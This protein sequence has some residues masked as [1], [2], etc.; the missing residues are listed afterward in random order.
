[1]MGD[2]DFRSIIKNAVSS[3]G[4]ELELD[5]DASDHKTIHAQEASQ[6]IRRSY[7]DRTDPVE[8]ER[9]GFNEL[10]SGLLRKLDYGSKPAEYQTGDSKLRCQ[11]DMIVD[12]SVLLFRSAPGDMDNPLAT[13]L[14]YLNACLWIYDK[15]DGMIVY[16]T[17]DRKETTFSLARDRGMFEEVVRRSKVL[18]DLLDSKKTPIV[19]P[20]PECSSCQYYERCYVKRTNT[21]Q[22]SLAKMFGMEKS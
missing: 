12:D 10:L 17:N 11:A 20:S 7:Y 18:T 16:I 15:P 14:L 9:R 1:M 5:I 6:C 21:K 13:D 22:L 3:I 8:I 4:R 19:E 2:R